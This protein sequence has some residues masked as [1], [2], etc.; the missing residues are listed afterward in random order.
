MDSQLD[1]LCQA[2]LYIVSTSDD[3]E[4]A[5]IGGRLIVGIIDKHPHFSANAFKA[6]WYYQCYELFDWS[7]FDLSWLRQANRL[8]GKQISKARSQEF[9]FNATGSDLYTA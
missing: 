6:R 7:G 1:V 4:E 5:E 9:G 3:S 2:G 8:A